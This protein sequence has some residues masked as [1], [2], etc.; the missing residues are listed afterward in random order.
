[1]AFKIVFNKIEKLAKIGPDV[2]NVKTNETMDNNQKVTTTE[3]I[4]NWTLLFC[5]NNVVKAEGM[6]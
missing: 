6:Q 3:L 2:D 5:E 4:P 1:M